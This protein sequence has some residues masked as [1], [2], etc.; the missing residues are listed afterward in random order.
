MTRAD[1]TE[2]V[3]TLTGHTKREAAE[4]VDAFFEMLKATLAKGE[5]IKIAGFGNF[6]VREKSSRKGRNPQTG[7]PIEIAARRVLTFKPSK[8]LT[9]A[10]NGK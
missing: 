4:M 6:E 1:I 9:N 5:K 7:V 2:N 8:T 3:Y 10:L